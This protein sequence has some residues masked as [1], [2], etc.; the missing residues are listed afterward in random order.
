MAGTD[1]N[2][3][4]NGSVCLREKSGVVRARVHLIVSV[5]VVGVGQ[6]KS[7]WRRAGRCEMQKG[8]KGERERWGGEKGGRRETGREERKERKG[9]TGRERK[10]EREREEERDRERGKRRERKGGTRE[11]R[12]LTKVMRLRCARP[13]PQMYFGS[14][15]DRI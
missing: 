7:Y 10:R 14:A 4:E 12:G 15:S 5:G 2:G 13:E 3:V 6:S 8:R 11:K 9:K 1:L